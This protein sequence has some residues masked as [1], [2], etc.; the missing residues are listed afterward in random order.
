MKQVSKEQAVADAVR[1]SRGNRKEI[2]ASKRAGCF[3]CGDAFPAKEIVEWRDEWT[4]PEKQ[5]R[6]PRWSAI[7]PE[8]GKATVIGD[9]SGL[10]TMQDY[11]MILKHLMQERH[12]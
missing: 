2:E 11:G 9:A 3:S 12:A 4:S 6:V 5:N 7:C 1:H 10:L 8:C